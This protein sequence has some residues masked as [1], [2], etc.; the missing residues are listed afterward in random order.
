[1]ALK[2]FEQQAMA[3]GRLFTIAANFTD[4]G[5][6][7]VG[8]GV[9]GIEPRLRDWFI[10]TVQQFALLPVRRT[11]ARREL[12]SRVRPRYG[13]RAWC[14]HVRTPSHPTRIRVS[15][16]LGLDTPDQSFL[17]LPPT[18]RAC[19]SASI[20]MSYFFRALLL[21]RHAW[22]LSASLTSLT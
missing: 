4:P 16:C 21:R 12:R 22:A 19:L 14:R 15:Q 8:G 5:T 7:F 2:V 20:S 13:R 1:M 18:N 10:A 9:V 17:A 11:G 6:Y 3:I